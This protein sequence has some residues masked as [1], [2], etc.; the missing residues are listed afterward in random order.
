MKLTTFST[1]SPLPG[2]RHWLSAAV[3]LDLGAEEKFKPRLLRLVDEA[4]L[5]ANSA[6]TGST[7]LAKLKSLLQL[8]F[9]SRLDSDLQ[10]DLMEPLLTRLAARYVMKEKKRSLALDPVANFHL[11]NGAVFHQ[12]NWRGNM[13]SK[14]WAESFG[15]MVNYLY[16]LPQLETN[17]RAYLI[18]RR[19]IA[20]KQVQSLID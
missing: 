5:M 3:E 20:S 8:P 13:T 7:A 15:L 9:E 11:R 16:D 1:L 18:D 12:L 14:G 4:A 19:I 2:F 6:L 10:F 17:N